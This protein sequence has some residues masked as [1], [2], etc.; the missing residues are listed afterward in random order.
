MQS[1]LYVWLPNEKIYPGGPVYLAD[2]V[3]K[4]APEVEQNIIDLS[5]IE[6]KK[7]RMQYL[8][9]KIDEIGRAHV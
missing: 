1:I 6:G 5:R 7:E 9:R 2:Y 3:H 4:K 8:H